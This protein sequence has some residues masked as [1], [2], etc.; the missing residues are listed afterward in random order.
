MYRGGP[1]AWPLH[2]ANALAALAFRLSFGLLGRKT[3][4][5][6]RFRKLPPPK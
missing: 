4:W 3:G 1:G 2:L 6:G 5:I